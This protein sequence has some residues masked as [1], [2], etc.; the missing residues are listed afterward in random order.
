MAFV[1][2]LLCSTVSKHAT[3]LLRLWHHLPLLASV[4]MVPSCTMY[5]ARDPFT[6]LLVFAHMRRRPAVAR[7]LPSSVVCRPSCPFRRKTWGLAVHQRT[8]PSV[9][10][11]GSAVYRKPYRGARRPLGKTHD[12]DPIQTSFG[13]KVLKFHWL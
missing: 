7:P 12:L 5:C 3:P 6:K 11:I 8:G 10:C 2:R 1:C 9:F 4:G 13:A